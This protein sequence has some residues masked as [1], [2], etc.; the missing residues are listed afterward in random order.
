MKTLVSI[1]ILLVSAAGAAAQTS[2]VSR[3]PVQQQ[4]GVISTAAV[5]LSKSNKPGDDWV[6][7]AGNHPLEAGGPEDQ[8]RETVLVVPGPDLLPEVIPN[9]AEDLTVMCRIFDKALHPS[10]RSTGRSAY[11]R[12]GDV[13]LFG[14]LLA[15]QSARTQGLYLDGYGAVFFVQ[16]DFPL[17]APPREKEAVKTDE[18]ADRVWSQTMN[19]L[20]GQQE[21]ADDT[22]TGPAYDAQKVDNL[23][24][25]LVKTLRHAANLRVHAQDRI[26]IVV[27]HPASA[28]S[29][30]LVQMQIRNRFGQDPRSLVPIR[31]HRGPDAA[32]ADPAATLVLRAAKA[33]IDDLAAGKLTADQFAAKV[34]MFWSAGASQ[35]AEPAPTQPTR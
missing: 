17:V 2:A 7:I 29:P 19:E 6:A 25:L 10:G 8:A 18:S 4:P 11:P 23:K 13:P 24:T 14:R 15:A 22:E 5:S 1:T 32:E 26:T 31:D 9:V 3:T 35:P 33:D 20:R 27:G 16:A 30:G 28:S 21:P 12:T 34:Q